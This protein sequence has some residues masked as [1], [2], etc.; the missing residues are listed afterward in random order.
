RPPRGILT[1]PVARC[2]SPRG[3][4]RRGTFA[5]APCARPGYGERWATV[6]RGGSGGVG[7]L[8]PGARRRRPLKWSMLIGRFAGID[9]FVHATFPL[10]LL[11]VGF[12]Y[13]TATGT[14]AGVLNGI[15]FILTLFL[16]VVLHE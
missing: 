3:A 12:H 8:R 2:T 6:V 4:A 15:A 9:V 16:C 13:W 1:A 5:L 7:A 11:W 10:L 14:V